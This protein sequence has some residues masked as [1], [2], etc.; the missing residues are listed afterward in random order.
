M[1]FF[2][3][4]FKALGFTRFHSFQASHVELVSSLGEIFDLRVL[5]SNRV[6][7]RSVE[8]ALASRVKGASGEL[9]SFT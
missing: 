4:G 5:P 1:F 6:V 8:L 2:L 3:A 7:P 9:G